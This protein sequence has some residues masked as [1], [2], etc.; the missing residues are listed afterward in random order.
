M[1]W[2]AVIALAIIGIA[3]D[4][5]AGDPCSDGLSPELRDQTAAVIA[6]LQSGSITDEQALAELNRL[7]PPECR[8]QP[9]IP[10]D[11]IKVYEEKRA[12]E[13]K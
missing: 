9:P 12:A 4:A 11:R 6:R 13:D 10:V 2:L 1:R 5:R 7:L 3:I 8:A